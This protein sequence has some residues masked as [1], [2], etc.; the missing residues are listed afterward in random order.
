MRY[1]MKEI[2]LGNRKVG[3][4]NP[5]YVIAEMSANHAGSLTYAKEIIHVAK[6]SGADCVKIQTYTPD[7]M[8]IDCYNEYFQIKEGTWKGENLY[9]LYGKAYTPWEW[10]PELKEEAKKAGIDFFSTPFDKSAVDFL[11][12]IGVEFYKI[13]SFELVDIPLLAYTASKGKPMI[14]STGMATVE[15]IEEAKQAIYAQ[16]NEQLILLKCSSAYPA[17]PAEMN[18]RT[19]LDMK[20]RF[21]VPVGLSDHSLGSMSAVTAVAM[22]ASVIE[23][24]FCISREIENPDASFSMTPEEFGTMVKDIRMTESAMGKAVYGVAKQEE[25]SIVFRRSLFAVED[26]KAGE[27]FSEQNI[28]SIRPGYGIKPKHY[29]EILG[30]KA[31]RDIKRGEPLKFEMIEK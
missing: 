31:V 18:I 7:T 16:G 6:E 17:N 30:K 20:E 29:N 22:G 5:A 26:I 13:A 27:T 3:E 10:Q 4:G 12:D 25:S 15:E 14:V 8:T 19:M 23:K 9:G 21:Q 24:H 11:E 1:V 28:R 2:I